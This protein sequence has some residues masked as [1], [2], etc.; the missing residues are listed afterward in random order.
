MADELS[1]VCAIPHGSRV[2]QDGHIRKRA[3]YQSQSV[4]AREASRSDSATL[5]NQI[6]IPGFR[7]HG[8]SLM[9]FV[10]TV[11][12]LTRDPLRSADHGRH[13]R[14]VGEH[15]GGQWSDRSL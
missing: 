7:R 5:S 15:V 6:D 9:P 12:D 11:H 2:N 3:S 10:E 1:G 14:F 8:H 4:I 13:A